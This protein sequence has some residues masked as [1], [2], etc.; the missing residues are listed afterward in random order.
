M[1]PISTVRG[2]ASEELESVETNELVAVTS[3]GIAY[4]WIVAALVI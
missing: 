4:L 3:Q 2:Y 1:N